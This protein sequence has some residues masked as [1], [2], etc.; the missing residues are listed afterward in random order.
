MPVG[1][2]CP[3]YVCRRNQLFNPF[4]SMYAASA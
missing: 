2:G 1:T 3:P 4:H